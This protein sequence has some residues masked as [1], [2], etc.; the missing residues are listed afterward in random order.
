MPLYIRSFSEFFDHALIVK[1]ATHAN[2]PMPYFPSHL[3][4]VTTLP[5]EIQKKI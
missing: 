3:K 5:C 2:D 4:C 1:F